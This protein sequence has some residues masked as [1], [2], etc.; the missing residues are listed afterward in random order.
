MLPKY[1]FE[2]YYED[3]VRIVHTKK[4]AIELFNAGEF[5]E[6]VC[7][8]AKEIKYGPWFRRLETIEDITS[9]N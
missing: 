8:F 4:E 9:L 1:D 7:Y 5:Y 2:F 3:K 6:A